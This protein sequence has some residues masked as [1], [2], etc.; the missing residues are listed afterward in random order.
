MSHTCH[1][2]GCKT[3]CKPEF[4][5]CS[6]HWRMVPKTLQQAVYR[7]YQ[8]GQCQ[9]NPTPSPEWHKAADAAIGYVFALEH[10]TPVQGKLL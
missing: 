8:P 2:R 5:M 4:L 10:P 9:G 6:K 1:A 7:T 3:T